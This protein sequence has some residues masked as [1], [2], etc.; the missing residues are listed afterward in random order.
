MADIVVHG[1]GVFGLSVAWACLKRG[2]R[3]TVVDP[4]GVASGAS[5]GLVGALAPHTPENWNDKKALQFR[6]L[7]M[8]EAL[9][10]EVAETSGQDP[11]YA[12]LGRVQPVLD[13]RML[14]LAR[15]REA[16][17][18]EVWKGRYVWQVRE[19]DGLVALPTGLCIFDS[20]SARVHP[21]R[22][23][24]ALAAAFEAKGGVVQTSGA[25]LS[26]IQVWATGAAGLEEMS[27]S[28][29]AVVGNGVKGQAAL[30]RCDLGLVP[31]VFADGLHIVPHRDGTVAIGST[32]ERDYDDPSSTDAQLDA[33]IDKARDWVPALRDA[34]VIDRWAGL[35]PRAKSRAPMIGPHPLKPGAYIANGGFKIGFGMAPICAE[36]LADL[37]LEGRDTIPDS[38]RP[39]ASF[40]T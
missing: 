38:F 9:W 5:G 18:R 25:G 19:A 28:V 7:E 37:I 21:R 13:D 33:L 29:G 27:A 32:S 35:R 34:P 40:S 30:L 16:S 1:A 36:L 22:A 20:L 2:A 6:S 12:R 10:A 26:G 39:E 4:H 15:T 3:V 24:S 8:A 14:D 17:A 31:Q 11:G 23:T